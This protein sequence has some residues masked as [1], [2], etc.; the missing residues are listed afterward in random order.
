MAS[1]D[2]SNDE[3]SRPERA[4]S[5]EE[6]RKAKNQANISSP[7]VYQ[8]VRAEGA[9]ELAR[10]T[11]S[12]W[13]SGLAAGISI[14][15]SMFMQGFLEGY[16][17]DTSWRPLISHFGYCAGFLIVVLARLQLFTEITLTAVLPLLAERSLRSLRAVLRLWGIVFIANMVGTAL[18]SLMAIHAHIAT[19][20]QLASFQAVAHPLIEKTAF[21]LLMRGIPAGFL[22]AAMVWMLAAAKNGHFWIITMMTYMIAIGGLTHVVVGSAEMFLLMFSGQLEPLHGIFGVLLPALVGNVIGGTG[23][24]A[25]LAYGQ[26]KAEIEV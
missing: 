26:V 16:L 23:L 18:A 15:S 1:T 12:L 5:S 20:E 8:V 4:L 24:F 17:P 14:S 11:L 3:A 2:E 19:P 13:F 21:D 6:S 22:I 10:P 9:Q 7:A 25:L